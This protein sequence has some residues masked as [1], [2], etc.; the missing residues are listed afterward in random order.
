MLEKFQEKLAEKLYGPNNNDIRKNLNNV[1]IVS[2]MG[3]ET[4][5]DVRFAAHGSPYYQSSRLDGLVT[6]DRA[7]VMCLLL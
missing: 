1:Q 2:V 5:T 6:A 3:D 4:H 7:E